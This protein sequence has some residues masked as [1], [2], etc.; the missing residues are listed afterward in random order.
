MDPV[1]QTLRKARKGSLDQQLVVP[2]NWGEDNAVSAR[3]GSDSGGAGPFTT[4]SVGTGQPRLYSLLNS[5]GSWVILHH[6]AGN[7]QSG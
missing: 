7:H 6:M 2:A 1:P 5:V 4:V 3:L